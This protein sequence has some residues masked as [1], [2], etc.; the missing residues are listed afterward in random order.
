M[1]L[2]FVEIYIVAMESKFSGEWDSQIVQIVKP[3]N[4][5]HSPPIGDRSFVPC[6]EVIHFSEVPN[7]KYLLLLETVFYERIS[8]F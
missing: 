4:K 3:L 6:I 1:G 2:E 5:G 7:G 8:F